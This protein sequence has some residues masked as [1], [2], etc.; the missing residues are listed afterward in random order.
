MAKILFVCTGNICRSPTAEAVMRAMCARAEV[1][2]WTIESAGV[3]GWHT[4]DPPDSRA[5]EAAEKRG[6]DMKNI[7][8]RQV[9]AE[10]YRRFNCIYA[11]A[12]E[13]LRFLR[14]NA[15]ADST[16]AVQLFLPDGSDV[17]DPYYGG[18][19]GFE[20]MMDL[21]EKGCRVILSEFSGGKKT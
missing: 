12:D 19:A 16:A 4:G 17:P 18:K 3:G 1:G 21:L 6:Y 5:R 20:D 13:H 15:P 8:A 9:C 11:M 2:G 7:C 10:D 14:T